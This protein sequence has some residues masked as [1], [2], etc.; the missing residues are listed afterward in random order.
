MPM[1]NG[2][3][4]RAHEPAHI[5]ACQLPPAIWDNLQKG[6]INL[7][8]QI[9]VIVSLRKMDQEKAIIFFKSVSLPYLSH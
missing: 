6:N 1:Y 5:L 8:E 7:F 4:G 2:R 9:C 3:I